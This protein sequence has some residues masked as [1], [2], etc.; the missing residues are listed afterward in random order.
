MTPDSFLF[1]QSCFAP[2]KLEGLL[3]ISFSFLPHNAAMT[4]V[5]GGVYTSSWLQQHKPPALAR[6][7]TT[8]PPLATSLPYLRLGGPLD[9]TRC[10]LLSEPNL[11]PEPEDLP[12]QEM[13]QVDED[14]LFEFDIGSP[15]S[16]DGEEEEEIKIVNEVREV[17]DGEANGEDRWRRSSCCSDS[18]SSCSSSR[19]R[20]E[21]SSGLYE[22]DSLT[23]FSS[24]SSGLE[25]DR[26]SSQGEV[27]VQHLSL[28]PEDWRSGAWREE[29]LPSTP[30]T[31]S[32]PRQAASPCALG[33]LVSPDSCLDEE[34]M[35]EDQDLCME[36]CVR[37]AVGEELQESEGEDTQ[38]DL[39]EVTALEEETA[40]ALEEERTAP[41]L[42]EMTALALDD[43]VTTPVI[44]EEEVADPALEEDEVAVSDTLKITQ[45]RL[46]SLLGKLDTDKHYPSSGARPGRVSLAS[47]SPG[48]RREGEERPRLRKWS[49]L[50]TSKTPPT[51]PGGRKIVRSVLG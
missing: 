30:S 14:Y 8:F 27:E 1:F 13:E 20:R 43:T 28:G 7:G 17:G 5:K 48:T 10:R 23:A 24:K 3:N 37:E 41:A 18:S 16:S 25:S 29:P 45:D 12:G 4:E 31:P 9:S 39:E 36:C 33:P 51:T 50:K 2:S 42:E 11:G 32:T 22:P 35:L 38:E 34:N 46:A 26:R 19:S 47:S 49:S 15:A 21:R 6:P 40:P 44:E